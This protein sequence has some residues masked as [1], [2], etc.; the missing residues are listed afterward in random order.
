M[1][2]CPFLLILFY[3]LSGNILV[4]GS[5]VSRIINGNR[6]EPNKWPFAAAIFS[7]DQQLCG[8]TV[9]NKDTIVTAGHCL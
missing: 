7:Y 1:K 3:L 5:D 2:M 4:A 9:W 6:S 8:G